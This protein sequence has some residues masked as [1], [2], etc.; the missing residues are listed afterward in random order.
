MTLPDADVALMTL[1]YDTLLDQGLRDDGRVPVFS[2]D[3]LRDAPGEPIDPELAFHSCTSPW[4]T[5]LAEEGQW[6][7]EVRAIDRAGYHSVFFGLIWTVPA[8]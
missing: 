1:N 8:T 2:M 7:F 4:Q 5:P 6:A 3:F